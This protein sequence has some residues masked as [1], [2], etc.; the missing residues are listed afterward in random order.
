M[1]IYEAIWKARETLDM[2]I[3]NWAREIHAWA[4][5]KEWWEL[6][7]DGTVVVR[8]LLELL[9]LATTELAEAAEE[10]R[11]GMLPKA[12]Y[13]VDKE[14][15]RWP[16]GAV[17]AMD[18]AERL[19]LFGKTLPKPEGFGIEVGD[20]IIRL[21]DTCGALEIDIAECMRLKMAYNE[22]RPARH[23]GKTA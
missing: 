1:S 6:K 21:L 18:D 13:A 22:T 5:R 16:Y 20:A 4:R 23:G 2:S 7:A 9:M 15:K 14:G 11:N 3:N 10:V 17:L 12:V 8:N 19:A